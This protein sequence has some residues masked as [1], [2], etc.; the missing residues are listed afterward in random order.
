MRCAM[1]YWAIVCWMRVACCSL[2]STQRHVWL[3]AKIEG[4]S[5]ICPTSVASSAFA[6]AIVDW[7]SSISKSD[8]DPHRCRTA[9]HNGPAALGHGHQ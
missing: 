3:T 5:C 7:S 2:V 1:K 8:V 4:P 6:F 9:L